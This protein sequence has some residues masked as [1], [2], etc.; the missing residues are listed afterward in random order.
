VQRISL[1]LAGRTQE[2]VARAWIETLTA[3]I[4]AQDHRHLITVGE[5]PWA[6][7]FPGAKPLFQ[8]KGVGD[9][10]DFVSVHFYPERDQIGKAVQALSVYQLGKPLL[11][12]EVFPLKCSVA[13][14]DEF[15]TRSQTTAA[16]CL[17]FYW[18][19]TI[20]EYRKGSMDV[21]DALTCAWL[22]YFRGKAARLQRSSINN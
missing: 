7:V 3:A 21:S 15:I 2:A 20:D 12:E 8:A 4:R 9:R 6:L 1:D 11:I 5:I 13:Q 10:L 19:K 17:G 22:E 16:G 14:L 18:G